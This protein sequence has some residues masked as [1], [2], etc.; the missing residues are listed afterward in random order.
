MTGGGTKLC[1]GTPHGLKLAV[2]DS[3]QYLYH[4]NNNQKLT[5]TTLDGTIVWQV[6]GNFGQDPK[7][8]YRP[9]WFAIVPGPVH[10]ACAWGIVLP[11]S[12]SRPRF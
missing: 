1:S 3:K 6:D 8:A 5:K 7:L 10:V 9:T 12:Y 11:Q 2:E 4:A